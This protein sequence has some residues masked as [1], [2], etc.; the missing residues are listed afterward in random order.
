MTIGSNEIIHLKCE[1]NHAL[2]RTACHLSKNKSIVC[3]VCSGKEVTKENRLDLNYP[4]LLEEWDY[5]KNI[6]IV[7]SE[8]A[9]NSNREVH[10]KCK[11]NHEWVQGVSNRTGTRY[12]NKAAS[13]CPY[14]YQPSR[15]RNE[16]IINAELHQF[17]PKLESSV[18]MEGKELDIYIKELNLAVEYDGEYWHKKKIKSDLEKNE[19]FSN[20]GI[21]IIRIREDKLP[22][23]KDSDFIYDTKTDLFDSI[24]WILNFILENHSINKRLKNKIEKYLKEKK[25]TNY[26]YLESIMDKYKIKKIINQK[27]FREFSEENSLPLHYYGQGSDYRAKWVCEDCNTKWI[28]KIKARNNG[29]GCPSCAAK[30]KKPRTKQ[31]DSLVKSIA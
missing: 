7:P 20:I 17:F 23:L 28:T 3:G 5:D 22:K 12:K 11:N 4:D 29:T 24:A 1:K 8:I 25:A 16:L 26:I 21:N 13:K 9:F 18:R 31:K 30:K 19:I 2:E 14:C 27:L 15:S 6:D 10:W